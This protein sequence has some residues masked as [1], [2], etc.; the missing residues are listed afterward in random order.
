MYTFFFFN[1]NDDLLFKTKAHDSEDA[2][3]RFAKTTTLWAE[4]P[5][6]PHEDL[7]EELVAVVEALKAE[8]IQLLT[9]S[10]I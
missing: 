4:R 9:N 10:P 5:R 1:N 2:W 3:Q 7:G 6:Y 8:G